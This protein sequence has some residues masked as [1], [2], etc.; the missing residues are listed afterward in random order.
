[1]KILAFGDNLI[2]PDML[3]AGLQAF[4]DHGD[5]VTIRDW[6]HDSVEDLQ[7]DNIKVEQNGAN[8]I[9]VDDPKLLKDI[10]QFDMIIT[11]FT[12][13][14]KALIDKATNLKYIG[15]L[16]GG[17][18]NI[19]IPYAKSKG[20]EVMNTAGRNA[21][22]VA[23][24]TVG[25]ML[26]LTRNIG[27]MNAKMHKDIWFKDFPNK[28]NVPEIGGKTVG[29]VGFGHIGQLVGQFLNGMGARII[30]YDPYV[31]KSDFAEKYDDLDKLVQEA[32]IITLHMR[33]TKETHHIINEHVF[34]LMGK[35]TYFINDAR[36]ALVDEQALIKA[37][38]QNKIAGAALDTYD[39]EPLPADSPLLSLDNVVLTS[40]SAGTTADAFKN[41]PKLFAKRFLASHK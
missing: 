40:H 28:G 33:A 25:L 27:L 37:L 24:F 7:A 15:V 3:K 6:S 17:M 39:H 23:E 14:G 10:D 16:R 36:S 20:I 4:V 41:T 30:Y 38:Q 19:D 18:E 31:N 29:I 34:E 35:N 5:Q 9:T 2:S 32:D 12:P 11:Q 13:I 8:C 22:A 21:R 26:A 1:M